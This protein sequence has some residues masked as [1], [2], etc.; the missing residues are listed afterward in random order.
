MEQITAFV[1]GN[2]RW[3]YLSLGFVALWYLRGFWWAQRRLHMGA[4]ILER[5]TASRERAFALSMLVLLAAACG[6]VYMTAQHISPNLGVL[7]SPPVEDEGVVLITAA[8][9]E[10]PDVVLLLGQPTLTPG[11]T[12]T[13]PPQNT[14]VPATGVGCDNPLAIIVSPLP[15]A[16]LSGKVEVRGTADIPDFAFYVLEI[17]TLGDNW[18]NVLTQSEPVS[19]GILGEWDSTRHVP[20]EHAFRLVVYDA[21]GAFMEPCVIPVSVGG[22]P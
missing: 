19:A 5:E 12:A 2:E 11:G 14:S 10:T 18:L 22:A 3:L 1:E 20:G 13:L 8:P 7:L 16:V 4:Y 17:S 9:T 21:E 6:F 15:G